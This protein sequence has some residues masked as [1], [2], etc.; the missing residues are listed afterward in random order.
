MNTYDFGISGPVWLLILGV[1]IALGI[2]IFVYR[3]TIPPLP[4]NKKSFLT[5]LRTIA[6]TILIVIVFEPVITKISGS[7]EPP[8]LYVLLDNSISTG[9]KDAEG[10][11]SILFDQAI[12]NTDFS[13]LD[14]DQLK[15]SLFSET[16]YEIKEFDPD[17]LDHSGQITNISNAFQQM[18]HNTRETNTQ[19][20]L[21]ITD[22]SFN[23]GANPVYSADDFAKPVFIVGIGDTTQPRDILISAILTN[24]IAY[25]D[26]PFP[27]NVNIIKSGY[28]DTTITVEFLDNGKKID[29]QKISFSP[30]KDEYSLIFEYVPQKE[31]IRKF[32]FRTNGID[33]EITKKNNSLSEFVRVLENKRSI[34]IFAGSPSPDLSFIKNIL[35]DE[36][37]V[38]LKTYIQKKGDEFY[39]SPPKPQELNESEMIVFIGFPINSTPQGIIE[40]VKNELDRGKPFMFI[41]SQEV[42]YRKLNA[43]NEFLP[44]IVMSSKKNEFLVTPDIK[45]EAIGNPLLR[46][47]GN[48]EDIKLWNKLPPIFRTETFFKP[49]PESEIVATINVNNVP[50]NEPLILTRSFQNK[51]SIAILG[52]NIYRWKMLGYAQDVALGN[53]DKPDLF[54]TFFKNAYRWL[55]VSARDKNIIIRTTKTNYTSNENIELFAQ[56]YDAAYTPIDNA[57]VSVSI[58]G[59]DNKIEL[60]LKSMGNGR[61]KEVINSLPP[62]DYYYNG[63][64]TLDGNRLGQDDG[65]FS[66]GEIPLEYS[67]LTMNANLLRNIANRTG[68]K[69]YLPQN[70]GDFLDDLR[71]LQDYKA[72]P[73]VKRNE[74][75]LWNWPWLLAL[76]ILLLSSEWFFR[77][78]WG[79]I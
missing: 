18:I 25:I 44:F 21:I 67:D 69:F 26:N 54:A 65:R 57:N 48:K 55:S 34:A 10:D 6:L 40:M 77:K 50:I 59:N 38:E 16:A 32:T 79:L 61:Y 75:I 37:G 13:S 12:E 35:D 2:S 78:R 47:Y 71:S 29:E 45:S 39:G 43:L 28:S 53:E 30:E 60:L 62:G 58:T 22:G 15:I 66:V 27:V 68:G 49:K 52:Y 56:V 41:M 33:D 73:I 19:A 5:A 17:T 9:I 4:N 14:E 11:R 24:E 42:D 1:I 70:A 74:F 51:K 72:K 31:G 20:A 64:V 8:V 76:A 3:K 23:E 63:I 46:V 7:E 36:K